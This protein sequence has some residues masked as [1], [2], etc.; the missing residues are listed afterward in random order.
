M[1]KEK[2]MDEV[3]WFT[4][5]ARLT[6]LWL[7]GQA[8]WDFKVWIDINVG[9]WSVPLRS[10]PSVYLMGAIMMALAGLFLLFAGH[11]LAN[12]VCCRPANGADADDKP[13][14]EDSAQEPN[15]PEDKNSA[16]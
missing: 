11:H 3:S 9:W 7:V 1:E 16:S 10:S 8:L 2:H 5:G 4:V 13:G 6:G 12:I 15:T 14:E